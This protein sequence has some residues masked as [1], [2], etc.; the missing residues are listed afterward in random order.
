MHDGS[1]PKRRLSDWIDG[2]YKYTEGLPTN[3][4]FRKWV[5]ISAIA[6]AL[7]RK[8]W[9]HTMGS[10]LFPNLF[11]VLCSPPGTGKTVLTSI[12]QDFW[13]DLAK[14]P[15]HHMAPSSVSRASLIDALHDA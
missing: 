15:G 3:S 11:V 10:D 12:L 1:Q 9:V 4:L 14:S 8:T 5:G 6:G 13:A 2:F 7:E